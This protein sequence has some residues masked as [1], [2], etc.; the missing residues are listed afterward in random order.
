MRIDI[1]M[2]ICSAVCYFVSLICAILYCQA[3][4]GGYPDIWEN[5][6]AEKIYIVCGV[7][8]MGFMVAA[9]IIA[10]I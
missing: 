2:L 8:C 6:A 7:L 9:L 10:I 3:G 4:Y 5:K 1:V